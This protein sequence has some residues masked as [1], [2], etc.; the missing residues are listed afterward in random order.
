MAKNPKVFFDILIGKSQAGR[1]VMELFADK[2]PKTAENFR[3]LCTGEKGLGSSG[4][5]LHYKGSAFHRIIPSFMCQG[6]DFTR[7]N[8]TGGESIYGAKFADE[9]FKLHH[10]GPGV[11]SMANAGP[12]TNGSQFFICTAQ[13]SW[14]DGKHVVFGKVVDGYAVVQKME[15]VGS[16]SG[17]TS[18]TVVI[19]DCG[20]LAHD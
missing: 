16:G 5:P 14:L 13:T 9:N 3:A 15:A 1:V 20:Q 11:L 17:A 2:V 7:G 8:G 18:Q 6:G 12:N 10:T 19:E 4:K